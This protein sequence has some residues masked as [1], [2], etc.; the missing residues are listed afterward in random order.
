M[1]A[2][3]GDIIRKKYVSGKYVYYLI[4]S[5]HKDRDYEAFILLSYVP[6]FREGKM[7]RVVPESYEIISRD[8]Y[9]MEIL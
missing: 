7:Q 6:Y 2:K 1:K 5:I 8:E 9:I 4:K 3:I